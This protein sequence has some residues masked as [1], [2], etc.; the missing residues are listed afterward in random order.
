MTQLRQDTIAILGGTGKEGRGLALRFA[1][2]GFPVVIGSRDAAKAQ[3]KAL[4]L[5][6]HLPGA[7]ISGG[8]NTAIVAQADMVFLCVPFDGA[9]ELMEACRPFWKGGAVLV[10]TTVPLRFESGNAMLLNLPVPSGSEHL[11]TQLTAGCSLVAAFKTIAAHA[12]A[13]LDT[14]LDCDVLVCGD[15]EAAKSRVMAVAAAISGLRVLD[16]GPLRN[17]RALEAMC[18]LAIGLNRRYKAKSTRFRIVGL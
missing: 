18:A 6:E 4:G 2:A 3:Q 13:E 14:P 8:E 9:S 1:A 10:D 16:G 11:A 17:A 15:H 5:A 12:L 7:I